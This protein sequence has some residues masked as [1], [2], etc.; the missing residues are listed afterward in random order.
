MEVGRALLIR[1]SWTRRKLKKGQQ[2]I[3]LDPGLSFGTG[4]HPTTKFCLEQLV[5]SRQEGKKQSFL[6]IGTGSGILSIAATKLGYAPVEAFD[7]DPEAVRIARENAEQNRVLKNLR[8]TRKDLTKIPLKPARQYDVICANLIY[9]LLLEQKER[10]I[11]R[12]RPGGELIL[13]GILQTQFAQVRSAFE[14]AGL[15]LT[16]HRVEGEWESGA[17]T[18][19]S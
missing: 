5:A 7:F 14:Q 10:I 12:L 1:P 9:D 3:V 19:V 15:R 17:F 11:N 18:K 6:D 16:T 4:Q 2:E 8:I 13:A